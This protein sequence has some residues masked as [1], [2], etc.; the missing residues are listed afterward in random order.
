MG[1]IVDELIGTKAEEPKETEPE[2][3]KG[4]IPDNAIPGSRN[5]DSG[6]RDNDVKA[7]F[8]PTWMNKG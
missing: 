1:D 8:T 4:T 5:N 7:M 6:S 2:A 3:D